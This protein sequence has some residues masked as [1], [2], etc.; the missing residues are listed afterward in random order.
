MNS[1]I[2]RAIDTTIDRLR[3]LSHHDLIADWRIIFDDRE[4]PP[5]RDRWQTAPRVELDERR[6]ALWER[7][8]K[9][10]WFVTEIEIPDAL[11]G[12]ATGGQTLR[13]ALRWWAEDA[14]IFAGDREIMAGDLYDCF[15]R[16]VLAE[17][18]EPGTKIALAIRL[19]SPGHDDGALVTSVLH[20]ESDYAPGLLDSAFVADEVAVV[21]ARICPDR[22]AIS[23]EAEDHLQALARLLEPVAAKLDRGATTDEI[24]LALADLHTALVRNFPRDELAID[25]LTH[26]HLDMAWLWPLSE[27]YDAAQRTFESVLN[28]QDDYPEATYTHSSPALYDWIEQHRPDLFD[29]IKTQVDR[30]K[31]DVAAGLWVEPELNII[32]GESIARQILYGQRYCQEK[33]GQISR[34]A[35]LPDSFGFCWQLPQFLALGG[36]DYFVTQKLRWNDTTEF[37]HE[38]FC[39]QAPDGT[40]IPAWMASPIGTDI[41]PVA[42]TQYA[43]QW[44]YTTGRKTAMWLPGA[45]DHGGGPTRDMLDRVRRW[46]DSPV[47]PKLEFNTSDKFLDAATADTDDLPVWNSELYLELH[48][49]CFTT[50]ASQKWAN[51]Q[52]EI[53]LYQA[54]LYASIASIVAGADYPAEEL[55][56]AWK[57]VLLN[58]FHDILPGSAIPEVFVDANRGWE[59]AIAAAESVREEA[60]AQLSARLESVEPPVEE[61]I[62][63]LVFNPT[64]GRRSQLI[65]IGFESDIYDL[66]DDLGGVEVVC[67]YDDRGNPVAS[68]TVEDF[69]LHF[70]ATD[71]PSLGVKRYWIVPEEPT[72]QPDRAPENF[73]LENQYLR[74]EID[75]ATG[76]IAR[77]FD[78]LTQREVLAETGGNRLEA[79]S[80]S[81]QYWDA[82]NI[83]P[84]YEQHP[85]APPVLVSI[86]WEEC[87]TLR[88][89]LRVV[90]RLN[91]SSFVQS[92]ILDRGSPILEIDSL[93]DWQERH[94]V[95]KAAFDLAFEADR[96]T[97]ETPCGAIERPIRP[98]T[99][100]ERAQWEVP[101]LQWCD[102]ETRS[103]ASEIYGLSLLNDCK[104]GG[105]AKP[106]RLRLTLLRGSTWPDPEADLGEHRFRYALYPHAGTW[107]TAGTVRRALAFNQP[108][109]VVPAMPAASEASP[110]LPVDRD[111][112]D[113]GDDNLVL[114]A[115]KRSE[116]GDRWL[117]RCHES[118]G[119]AASFEPSGALG[120]Q[121]IDTLDI[122][123][124]PHRL[125]S[126]NNDTN[127][128]AWKVAT[129]S[130]APNPTEE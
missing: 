63:L 57:K 121:A 125:T 116:D 13:L 88:Q 126:Q 32:S 17:R 43:A 124:R 24:D 18:A 16:V 105:D 53:L 77:C 20:Y 127:I 21:A 3:Q 100:A 55:E 14:R 74:V 91:Q 130:I 7:G 71:L 44:C 118:A 73:T 15:G 49:G 52:G 4:M 26:A 84:D 109:I 123:E 82:W 80:D 89:R 119:R 103:E 96:A 22:S 101:M 28:L 62:P 70:L 10:A 25:L 60:I 27:T 19:V 92:Y 35:W 104:Y 65:S 79:Y 99:A 61:A 9:V 98:Q 72:P 54:E 66:I 128:G 122:L 23:T 86:V 85:L 93:V 42:M 115:L 48:R 83:D 29:R 110:T 50:Y 56:T 117:L 47:L 68:E 112:L 90:R 34:V 64:L 58:Q 69:M 46:Q 11:H 95:V 41:D 12:Y 87:G 76:N 31:W 6:Y 102:V 81:G 37:P 114:M 5:S 38:L 30:G 106:D 120:L 39:W 129:F 67:V 40:Q 33:F 111:W 1:V 94:V 45:G 78:K 113:L 107:Q 59:A 2:F 8:R 51:R 108:P 75:P 36:I 97:Y